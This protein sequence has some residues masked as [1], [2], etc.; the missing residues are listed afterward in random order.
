MNIPPHIDRLIKGLLL[1]VLS[2]AL[3]RLTGSMNFQYSDGHMA[4]MPMGH[5]AGITAGVIVAFA[6]FLIRDEMDPP[7]G[8]LA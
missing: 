2:Y 4:P 8:I 6:L 3:W 5:R 7:P 1:L